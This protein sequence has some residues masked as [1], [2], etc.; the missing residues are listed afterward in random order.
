MRE[1]RKISEVELMMI[2]DW[3]LKTGN[4][5]LASQPHSIF[6]FRFSIWR[7]CTPFHPP[8]G[9]TIRVIPTKSEQYRLIISYP[10]PTND[11]QF[12]AFVLHTQIIHFH[13]YFN[14]HQEKII[15]KLYIFLPDNE[16]FTF[17]LNTLQTVCSP[18]FISFSTLK[19]K[20]K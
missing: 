13:I 17:F 5:Y 9:L 16:N 8:S 1:N 10:F 14:L 7:S 18:N 11:W 3:R 19:K 15:P 12:L 4:V 6:R 2:I 20:I